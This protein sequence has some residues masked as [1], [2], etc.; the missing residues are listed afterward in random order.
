MH[1]KTEEGFLF[2]EQLTGCNTVASCNTIHKLVCVQFV[3]AFIMSSGKFVRMYQTP[4][5]VGLLLWL[6]LGAA[7][8]PT[9]SLAQ[10]SRIE[11][12]LPAPT[13][14]PQQPEL[15]IPRRETLTAPEGAAEQTFMLQ[16]LD[17]EGSTVYEISE[18]QPFYSNLLGK[19]VSLKDLYDIASNITQLYRDDGYILSLA[20]VPEQTIVDGNA[21][22]QVIEGY[23]EA[24][25]FEGASPRQL[26]RLQGFGDKIMASRP[27]NVKALERYLLLANDL[28]GFEVRAILRRGTQLGSAILLTRVIYDNIDPFADLTNRGT[29]EVGPLRLQGGIFLNSFLG[30]G[31]LITLRA[32]TTPLDPGELALGSLE[33]S[34]PVG[35][36]GLR[37]DIGT[38]YTAI[39]SGGLL[40]PFDINGRTVTA[41]LAASYP[42]VRSRTTNISVNGGFD[43]A[44]SRN[45]TG[46]T[47]TEEVLNQDR[48]QVLRAGVNLESLDGQGVFTAS[49]LISQGIGGTSPSNATE[50]L[51]RAD[52][53]AI[54]TKV[55]LNF[56]RLQRLPA[57]FSLL[58]TST[59]QL[60]GDTLLVRELFGLGGAT[61]GSAFEPD[62]LLGDYG[63]GLRLELQRTL[64]YQALGWTNLTQPYIYADVG[65]VFRHS[66]TLVEN[67]SDLLSSAGIGVRHNF[68]Q[69][70]AARLELGIPIDS[71]SPLFDPSPRVFFSITGFY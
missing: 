4:T 43:Y 32:A 69:S 7:I 47:G 50:P 30:Q 71:S 55:N 45:T 38:S 37:F 51:S 17:V 23:I 60:T 41:S 62:L 44:D 65:Q 40:T 33:F 49:A 70:L 24:V 29:D 58:F 63:Y 42:I 11:E 56:S 19:E 14:P 22:I 27:I 16:S 13:P 67:S 12:Q 18:L 35:S 39:Q 46:F 52:G 5:F 25:E 26:Q 64:T 6:S 48:L 15:T 66:P 59:A 20:L 21:R 31:E 36:E 54:F 9:R 3:R 68:G 10:P 61:F 34:I 2:V 1:Y 53:S 28:A 57:Q 8:Y